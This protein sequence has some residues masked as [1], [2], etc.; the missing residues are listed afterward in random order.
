MGDVRW[1]RRLVAVAA[2][3]ATRPAGRV[4]EVIACPAER[5]AAFRLLGNDAATRD[6]IA[7][8]ANR[9]CVPCAKD[10]DFVFVPVDGSSLTS[11]ES[12]I[13]WQSAIEAQSSAPGRCAT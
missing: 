1:T 7:Q 13:T 11:P 12:A 6:K 2:A 10:L 3:A 5:T 4:T 8:A 9:A